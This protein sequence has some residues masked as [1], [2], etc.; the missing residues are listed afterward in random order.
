MSDLLLLA[1][2]LRKLSDAQLVALLDRRPVIGTPRDFLDL[3]QALLQ[4]KNIVEALSRLSADEVSALS[5]GAENPD[6]KLNQLG[7]SV[8]LPSGQHVLEAVAQELEQLLR[9]VPSSEPEE[10]LA[11]SSLQESDLN[12]AA[13]TFFETQQAIT[14]IILDLEQRSLRVVGRN[15]IGIADIKRL[16]Q[17][18]NQPKERI[19]AWIEWV[20]G[21]RLALPSN[22][23]WWLAPAAETWV[24][25]SLL[26]RFEALARHWSAT[27]GTSGTRQLQSLMLAEPHA[28]LQVTLAKV[29]PL[30]NRSLDQH[31]VRIESL[32]NDAGLSAGHRATELL[33]LVLSGQFEAART[34]LEAHLPRIK[35]ELIVQADLTL[36][37]PGPVTTRT[38]IAIRQFA[39]IENVGI[40]SSYRMNAASLSLAQEL[41]LKV[42][43]IRELLTDLSGKPL[44][45]PVEYLLREAEQRFGR[46][47]IWPKTSDAACTLRSND[48]LLLTEI[49]N[50]SRL[51]PFGFWASNAASLASRFEPEVVYHG[52]RDLG[53]V[54]VLVDANGSVQAPSHHLAWTD[55]TENAQA[56]A[57]LAMVAAL[58][59]ADIKAGAEPDDQDLHR[60]L[61]LAIKTKSELNVVMSGRDGAIVE[62]RLLPTSLAN[63]RLRALD[64]KADAERTL[65][66]ER[67]LRIDY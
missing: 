13:V 51:R 25:A 39:D 37:A 47:Q 15:G 64:R 50:D 5:G 66:V 6:V 36:I 59:D 49:L 22:A 2:E 43:N 41:G 62:F 26:D 63:G 9:K 67:I 55:S 57:K 44:P 34:R 12:S 3:A 14:E 28:S 35:D 29:F 65:P 4:P 46:L 48:S 60:Q 61:Q 53:Y 23:R 27:L 16:S 54:A 17:H 33:P 45:Q 19:R 20:I 7:L 30:A 8:S 58:R 52:L 56:D 10:S 31:L 38:E 40:A 21:M 42:S 24:S 11:A 32:A 18:L 1:G